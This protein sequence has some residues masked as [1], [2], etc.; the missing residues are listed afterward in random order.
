MNEEAH[1]LSQ[2]FKL[3]ANLSQAKFGK[4]YGIGSGS[5]VWQYLNGRRPLSLATA[6]KFARGLQVEIAEFS[7]RLAEVRTQL[8]GGIHE[9]DQPGE[10]VRIPCV[11]VASVSGA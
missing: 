6:A 2:L 9:G 10:F 5:M 1:R 11:Q 7:Q 8:A 4:E 3:R